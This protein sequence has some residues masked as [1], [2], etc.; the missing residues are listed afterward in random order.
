MKNNRYPVNDIYYTIQGEGVYTGQPAVFLRLHGCAVGCPF[1]D[2]KETW[3]FETSLEQERISDI[4][5]ANGK[6]AYLSGSEINAY[7][8][9]EFPKAIWVVVT[10]G[11]PAQYPLKALVTALHDGGLKVAIETSG[12][13]LGFVDAGFDW[14]TVSPKIGMPGGKTIKPTAIAAADEI[15][16]VVG[17]QAHIDQLDQLLAEMPPKKG[18]TICLQPMSLSPKAT[19]LAIQTVKQRG[20]RLSIQT[21][22][23]I[24]VP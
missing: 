14:I 12:T 19:E 9:R 1:C 10:G 24:Q 6:H 11:E 20:W 2:T 18:A 13:E 3:D 23:Y 5:G 7:I 21:H 8:C 17:K 15:K 16:H 4:L 22:K